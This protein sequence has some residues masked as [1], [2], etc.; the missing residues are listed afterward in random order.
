MRIFDT[1]FETHYLWPSMV[2]EDIFFVL[3]IRLAMNKS[4]LA[5][6]PIRLTVNE[7]SWWFF[8]TRLNP[9]VRSTRNMFKCYW[10]FACSSFL[11]LSILLNFKNVL[12]P[13][14][15]LH[16]IIPDNKISTFLLPLLADV[17]LITCMYMRC[18]KVQIY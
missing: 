14:K 7:A 1:F 17:V 5:F 15:Y 2:F 13:P 18:N 6:R 12:F 11:S 16:F 10:P 3:L 9:K 4:S 8:L